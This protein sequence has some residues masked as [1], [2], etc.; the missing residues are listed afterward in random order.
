MPEIPK[1]EPANI[2]LQEPVPEPQF[3]VI[4]EDPE[5]EKEYTLKAT[6]TCDLARYDQELVQKHIFFK[7][8]LMFTSRTHSFQLK[9]TSLIQMKYTLQII[10]PHYPE[11]PD[12]G[13]FEAFPRYGEI[14]AGM[15]ED[16]RVTFSPTEVD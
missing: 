13:Y 4:Q 15:T 1:N 12:A 8:T 9:N 2:S 3:E 7:P 14:E 5:E 11:Y 6:A 16:I 10:N